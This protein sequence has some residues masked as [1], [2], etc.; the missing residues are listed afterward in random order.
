MNDKNTL[1]PR[2]HDILVVLNTKVDQLTFDIKDIKDNIVV[3]IAKV[4]ARLDSMDVY[5]A[6]IPLKDYED[7]ARWTSN[8]RSNIKFITFVGGLCVA[9]IG[10]LIERL[11]QIWFKF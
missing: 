9:I 10:A 7:I 6:G 2:D 1:V 4:E 8:F 11:M 3:R 5:H